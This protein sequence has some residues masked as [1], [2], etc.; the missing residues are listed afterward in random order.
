MNSLYY[1]N[2]KASL[3]S[4]EASLPDFLETEERSALQT[5]IASLQSQCTLQISEMEEYD[6]RQRDLQ[7]ICQSD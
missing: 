6:A 1:T 4:L 5:K 7:T 2:L 3:S